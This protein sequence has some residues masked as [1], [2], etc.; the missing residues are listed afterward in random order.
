[1]AVAAKDGK[2]A[3]LASESKTRGVMAR[4]SLPGFTEGA[5]VGRIDTF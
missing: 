5:V 4:R 3:P 1:M 2:K